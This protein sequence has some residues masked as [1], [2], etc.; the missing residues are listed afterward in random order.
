MNDT[1]HTVLSQVLPLVDIVLE[2]IWVCATVLVDVFTR[3]FFEVDRVG[4]LEWN[5][6]EI[7]HV[8]TRTQEE[9]R[10]KCVL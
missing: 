4:F 7:W 10:L 2:L 3:S 5:C 9:G 6:Q 1:S 8:L